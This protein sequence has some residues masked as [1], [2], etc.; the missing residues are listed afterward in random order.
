MAYMIRL[1]YT[2]VRMKAPGLAAFCC[3]LLLASPGYD[4]RAQEVSIRLYPDSILIG[5]QAE[6]RLRVKAPWNSSIRWPAL[7]TEAQAPIEWIRFGLPDT[8]EIAD[9]H[10]QLEAS[11][12][13]TA[14]EPGYHPIPPFEFLV[15]Y[16]GDS[17][18]LETDAVL[19]E[20]LGVE[21]DEAAGIRDIKPVMRWPLGLGEVLVYLI[22]LL[23]L[24]LLVWLLFR[25]LRKRKRPAPKADDIWERPEVPAHI[26][27][28]SR[29]E[30]LRSKQLWQQGHIKSYHSE[31]TDIL[32]RYLFKAYGLDAMEMTSAEILDAGRTLV[33]Q[34]DAM[35]SL[36][37]ILE[38]AD[39]V[40]FARFR[41]EDNVHE[42]VMDAAVA[43]VNQTRPKTT[44]DD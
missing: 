39:L 27:A 22:P 33:Q 25:Y 36:A 16:R 18:L 34:A 24:A 29:L 4:A 9:D 19:F 7:D 43:F 35:A 21:V 31:L 5:Q 12:L 10:Y 13:I 11:H 30:N 44:E 3:W 15:I 37:K 38:V 23:L 28:M 26:A 42:S 32:R 40:K 2:A 14:W 6:L 41:P 1:T 20:V 8:L 17:L